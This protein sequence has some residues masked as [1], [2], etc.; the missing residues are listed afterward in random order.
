[1]WV[2]VAIFMTFFLILWMATLDSGQNINTPV[3]QNQFSSESP[4]F[5]EIKDQ[6]PSLW[7]S[8]KA[9]I[10]DLLNSAGKSK[11]SQPSVEVQ[12]GAQQSNQSAVPPATLP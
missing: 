5:S 9:G 6:A 12:G 8:L 11:T 2:G 10:A 3:S 4:T 1:M 7:Q